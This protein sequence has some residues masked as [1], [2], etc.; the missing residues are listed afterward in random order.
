MVN[1]VLGF[2][3]VFRCCCRLSCCSATVLRVWP[4]VF[5]VWSTETRVWSTM[6]GFGQW[7]L[8]FG[9]Q[10]SQVSPGLLLLLPPLLLQCH[11]TVFGIWSTVFRFGQQYLGCGQQHLGFGQQCPRVYPGLL[12]QLP[13]LLQYQSTMVKVWSTVSQGPVHPE[14]STAMQW[15]FCCSSILRNAS[16]MVVTAEL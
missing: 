2:L 10:C 9:Q 14:S 1:S 3:Q 12:Q 5:R 15:S 6:S 4:T 11:S 16:L 8:G 13:L 7:R